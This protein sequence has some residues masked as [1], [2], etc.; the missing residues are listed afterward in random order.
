[1]LDYESGIRVYNED[2]IVKV[3]DCSKE[4]WAWDDDKDGFG[5]RPYDNMYQFN[6]TTQEYPAVV[7]NNL[8]C[9][10]KDANINP[11]A[12][13]VAGDGIDNNCNGAVDEADV[14][15]ALKGL[16]LTAECSNIASS[17]LWQIY[18]PNTCS[19]EVEWWVHKTNQKG[20]IVATP[21]YSTFTTTSIGK[22]DVVFISWLDAEGNNKKHGMASS[23]AKCDKNKNARTTAID[24]SVGPEN[25]QVYP[26]PFSNNFQLRY[27]Y[28]TVNSKLKITLTSV[29]GRQFDVSS[30]IISK[31]EGS[32]ALNLEGTGVATGLYMLQLHVDDQAP[33]LVRVIKQ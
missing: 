7:N 12:E 10:D 23:S 17:R 9:N 26:V 30:N 4:T 3:V 15:M 20:K 32:I 6:Y 16:H 31:A 18:N 33:V 2:V 14:C 19:V 5:D 1:M 28:I 21:G 25:L 27:H 13:E 8:D 11:E 29:D 22:N 24:N